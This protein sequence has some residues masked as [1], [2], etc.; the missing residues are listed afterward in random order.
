LERFRLLLAVEQSH[1][2]R[3]NKDAA[4]MGHPLL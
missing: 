3:K 2:S 1:P 4:R